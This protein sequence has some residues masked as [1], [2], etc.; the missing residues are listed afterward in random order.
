MATKTAAK[1][2]VAKYAATA[3]PTTTIDN[4]RSVRLGGGSREMLNATT[5][6]SSSA[7]E[8]LPAPLRDT[9]EIAIRFLY[10]P[11]DTIHE[12]VRAHWSAGTK[13]YLTLVAPDTGAA[14]FIHQGNVTEWQV[15]DQDP[16]TGLME[17]EITFKGDQVD[18]FS[19]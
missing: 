14:N 11:A 17:V 16:E 13:G 9:N 12:L 19:A 7:K 18:T 6:G 2:W 5:H 10:D 4:L 3:T 8:Y 15:I 1:G